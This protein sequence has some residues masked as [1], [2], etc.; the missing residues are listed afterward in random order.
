MSS[1]FF[2]SYNADVRRLDARKKRLKL[3]VEK[4]E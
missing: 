3:E 2:P 4:N 1:D